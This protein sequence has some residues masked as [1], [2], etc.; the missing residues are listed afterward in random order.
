MSP[1]LFVSLKTIFHKMLLFCPSKILLKLKAILRVIK[2]V[3]LVLVVHH[4]P[5]EELSEKIYLT[6]LTIEQ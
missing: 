6:Y 2:K 4:I 1:H 3:I 5:F